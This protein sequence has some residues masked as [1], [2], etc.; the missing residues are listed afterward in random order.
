MPIDPALAAALARQKVREAEHRR[1]QQHLAVRSA[2]IRAARAIL[3]WSQDKLAAAV[4]VSRLTINRIERG[5]CLPLDETDQH[6]R[7]LFAAKGIR[8][9][10]HGDGSY[11]VV[12]T[13]ANLP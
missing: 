9:E 7:D 4:G 5:R 6:L 3:G 12:Y 8:F 1:R 2:Q 10:S 11:R 13:L